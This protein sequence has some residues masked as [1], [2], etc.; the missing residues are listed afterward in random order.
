MDIYDDGHTV[1]SSTSR[2][3]VNTAQLEEFIWT[4]EATFERVLIP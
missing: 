4:T 3:D 1:Q 2:T